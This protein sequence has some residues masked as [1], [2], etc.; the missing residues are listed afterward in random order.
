MREKTILVVEDNPD[1]LEL[2]LLALG[3]HKNPSQVAVAR[4]G[5]EALDYL[6]ATGVHQGRDTS[7]QPDLILLDLKLPRL[8]G[9]EV[10]K[11]LRGDPRSVFIPVVILS[12]SSEAEDIASAYRNGANSFVRKPIDFQ[13]FTDK[14]QHLQVYWLSINITKWGA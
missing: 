13:E 8:S 11:R 6:F 12:S 4:D 14:L 3:K 1:H 10:L 9:L 5:V 2:T 7:L